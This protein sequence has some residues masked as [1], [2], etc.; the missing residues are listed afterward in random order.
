MTYAACGQSPLRGP[1]M[2]GK[3]RLHIYLSK[4]AEVAEKQQKI[5]IKRT[6]ALDE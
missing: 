5:E 4:P 3:R 1:R 6:K 2:G